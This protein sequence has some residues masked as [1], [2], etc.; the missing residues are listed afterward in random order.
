MLGLEGTGA[1][2]E[3][4][5]DFHVWGSPGSHFCA[6]VIPDAFSFECQKYPALNI[7]QGAHLQ[8]ENAIGEVAT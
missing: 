2:V 6:V 3:E 7:G 5:Y 4:L 8:H 1:W